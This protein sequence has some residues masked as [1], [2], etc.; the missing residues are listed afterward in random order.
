MA[1]NAIP[2]SESE[3]L[4]RVPGAVPGYE[5]PV[6]FE[7]PELLPLR[8]VNIAWTAARFAVVLWTVAIALVAIRTANRID[9]GASDQAIADVGDDMTIVVLIGVVLLVGLFVSSVLWSRT[10]AENT[11]RLRGRWPSLNRATRVW[12]YPT[13]WVALSALTFLRIEVTGEFNPLPAIAAIVFAIGL[14]C[15]FSMLH[16]IFKT[17][18]RGASRRCDPGGLPPR[19]RRVRGHLVAS[20]RLAGSDHRGRLGHRGCDGV[21]GHRIVR[22]A[23]DLG[24]DHGQPRPPS[25]RSPSAT[26][27]GSSRPVTSKVWRSRSSRGRRGAVCAPAS[28]MPRRVAPAP[29][30][31]SY[32]PPISSSV[33]VVL[34]RR[35]SRRRAARWSRV[36]AAEVAA[37]TRV[38]RRLTGPRCDRRWLRMAPT[39]RLAARPLAL[40]NCP[41]RDGGPFRARPGRS[42]PAAGQGRRPTTVTLSSRPRPGAAVVRGVARRP[43]GRWAVGT[44]WHGVNRAP[45][46]RVAWRRRGAPLLRPRPL[47]A[48]WLRR[49]PPVPRSPAVAG[50]RGC[51]YRRGARATARRAAG[52]AGAAGTAGDMA[53]RRVL[54]ADA[55][56][57]RKALTGSPDATTEHADG[58]DPTS[59]DA[60][61]RGPG[62]D[63][64]TSLLDRGSGATAG[65]RH[66]CPRRRHR[67]TARADDGR[68]SAAH[69][70]PRR[71][72][73]YSP[74]R[75]CG[76]SSSRAASRHR[77]SAAASM[78]TASIGSIWCARRTSWCSP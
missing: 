24:R 19:P 57:R 67:R 15:P 4:D 44:S 27:S 56:A 18:T 43:A 49:E 20:H 73:S 64:S 6:V 36:E 52:A 14:Y 7:A 53:A 39:S 31:T 74:R 60:I 70:R 51:R 55:A 59:S 72:T 26:G 1:A 13:V 9:S 22:P 69:P 10:V 40:V 34:H 76:S 45:R 3:V 61:R 29:S 47:G 63:G 65:R 28:T 12:F 33:R 41:T 58:G 77:R 68:R 32:G 37:R 75:L 42:R 11:R 2:K 71:R 30:A 62:I 38:H 8:W 50:R 17:L 46:R 21:G 16:R 5:N 25:D 35:R 23:A 48:A 54:A 66:Q 78:R